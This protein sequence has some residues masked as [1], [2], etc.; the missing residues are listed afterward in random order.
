MEAI[1]CKSCGG[2]LQRIS[3]TAYRCTHC[4]STHDRPVVAEDF[5]PFAVVGGF[6]LVVNVVIAISRMHSRW[7]L[8]E[9]LREA[10]KIVADVL[11]TYRQ[12]SERPVKELLGSLHERKS[13]SDRDAEQLAFSIYDK[14][15]ER[16]GA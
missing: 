12:M 1:V 3:P 15:A 2:T 5:D 16:A 8:D 9:L 7:R 11:A 13:M 4:G 10:E 14:V 6:I